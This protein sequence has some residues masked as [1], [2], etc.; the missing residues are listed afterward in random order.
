MLGTKKP[1]CDDRFGNNR[2]PLCNR[3]VGNV[4]I[5]GSPCETGVLCKKLTVWMMVV[6]VHSRL[7]QL[8][9]IHVCRDRYFM[10]NWSSLQT[11][12]Q[13]RAQSPCP[14]ARQHNAP[15]INQKFENLWPVLVMSIISFPNF[16][17]PLRKLLPS[18]ELWFWNDAN[19]LRVGQVL[20]MNSTWSML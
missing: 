17:S 12:V 5:I 11:S 3:A 13:N 18:H 10:K 1:N 16:A 2:H 9:V 4:H 7:Q 15:L 6:A 14:P 8:Q 19:L 20:K